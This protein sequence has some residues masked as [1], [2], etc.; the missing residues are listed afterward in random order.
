MLLG[1][2]EVEACCRMRNQAER[3]G[4]WHAGNLEPIVAAIDVGSDSIRK[5]ANDGRVL[6]MRGT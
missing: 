3:R 5:G 4:C 6:K 1:M 2:K